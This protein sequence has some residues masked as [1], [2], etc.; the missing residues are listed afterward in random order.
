MERL[1]DLGVLLQLL[2]IL[3]I[4]NRKACQIRGT[5][6]RCLHRL[7]LQH[8]DIQQ[9]CLELHNELVARGAAIDGQAL[10]RKTHILLHGTQHVIALIG[11]GLASG[12]HDGRSSRSSSQ[13]AYDAAG[14]RVPPRCTQARESGNEVAAL[15]VA[16]RGG[17]PCRFGY[18]GDN[19]HV[20]A[21]PV[22]R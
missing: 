12:A 22:H 7:T 9:V 11:H 3:P 6:R 15:V 17:E 10:D 1:D 4:P 18:V 16:D 14:V 20:V 2:Q 8:G 13:T 19:A 5:D 21:Q